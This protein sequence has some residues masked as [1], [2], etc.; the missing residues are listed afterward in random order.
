MRIDVISPPLH[1]D[2]VCGIML[3]SHGRDLPVKCSLPVCTTEFFPDRVQ[4]GKPELDRIHSRLIA[5]SNPVVL[6]PVMDLLFTSDNIYQAAA[7]L[8]LMQAKEIPTVKRYL[9]RRMKKA[10]RLLLSRL[11]Y[12]LD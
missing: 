12:I 4:K 5:S 8:M 11:D 6:D 1:S 3:L 10:A 9:M 2:L 7:V